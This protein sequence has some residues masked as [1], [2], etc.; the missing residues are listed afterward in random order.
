MPNQPKGLM[1]AA[2]F[3]RVQ[4]VSAGVQRVN[5]LRPHQRTDAA[6]SREIEVKI[7]ARLPEWT[8]KFNLRA[9]VHDD[10]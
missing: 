1:Q 6:L 10:L 2:A 5:R 8:E 9:A 7:Q 4:R 3:R